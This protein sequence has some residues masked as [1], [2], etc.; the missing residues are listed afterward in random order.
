MI[1]I[2]CYKKNK[3]KY[4]YIIFSNIYYIYIYNQIYIING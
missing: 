2:E 3:K 1:K 4:I